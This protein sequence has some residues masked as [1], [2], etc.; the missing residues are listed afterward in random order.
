MT[1]Q[2]LVEA[3]TALKRDEKTSSFEHDFDNIDE[4]IQERE[5]PKIET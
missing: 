1:D 5:I 4:V 2:K 3:D